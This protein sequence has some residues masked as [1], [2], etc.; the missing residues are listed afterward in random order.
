M[1]KLVFIFLFLCFSNI[2]GQD[3]TTHHSYKKYKNELILRAVIGIKNLDYFQ[4]TDYF[5]ND[6]MIT[7]YDTPTTLD[8]GIGI[9]TDFFGWH[10]WFSTGKILDNNP[11][12]NKR[13]LIDIQA[14]FYNQRLSYD[15][16][17]QH[18]KGL[19]AKRADDYVMYRPNSSIVHLGGNLLYTLNKEFSL[20]SSFTQVSKQYKSKGTKILFNGISNTKIHFPD[21]IHITNRNFFNL[22]IGGGYA[23]NFIYKNIFITF[24]G[25]LAPAIQHQNLDDQ[26]KIALGLHVNTRFG[27]GYN[28]KKIIYGVTFVDDSQLFNYQKNNDRIDKYHFKFFVGYRFY[29]DW[30]KHKIT[31]F[32]VD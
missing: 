29:H 11:K 1:K 27:I 8:F 20:P 2:F 23:Y 22:S 12:D 30:K 19:F 26:K 9:H 24:M 6:E 18:Y 25:A 31:A 16:N 10:F 32:L 21:E 14:N 4:K 17:F 7:D 15:I 3:S 5:K 13:K 28:G